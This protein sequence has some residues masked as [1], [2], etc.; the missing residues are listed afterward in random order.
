MQSGFRKITSRTIMSKS[1]EI[2][3]ILNREVVYSSI[4]TAAT[5]FQNA[6]NVAK[7]IMKLLVQC[8]R[9]T[10]LAFPILKNARRLGNLHKSK[11]L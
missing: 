3:Q 4:L 8:H 2:G 6:E 7:T 1:R 10:V 11:G 9:P 5:S